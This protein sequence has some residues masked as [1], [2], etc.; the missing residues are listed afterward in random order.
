[1]HANYIIECFNRKQQDLA[2]KRIKNAIIQHNIKFDG[3]VVTG[4]SG[5]AFGSILCRI[6]RKD[7]VIVRKD[8]DGSHS[9]YEV[10]NYKTNKRYIFLDDFV[11]S[12]AT[13]IRVEEKLKNNFKRLKNS[14]YYPFDKKFDNESEII[15]KMFYSYGDPWKPNRK[16]ITKTYQLKTK[17][18]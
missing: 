10:E 9:S 12:G 15:G 18:Q 8:N 11:A 13:F 16:E 14:S 4:V 7:L 3:F 17:I 5:V 1:M 6:L 2:I